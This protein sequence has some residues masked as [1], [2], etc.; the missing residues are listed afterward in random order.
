MRKGIERVLVVHGTDDVAES[1]EQGLRLGGF[2]AL[3]TDDPERASWIAAELRAD[4][5]VLDLSIRRCDV[6]DLATA[7]RGHPRTCDLPILALVEDDARDAVV[8]AKSRGCDA[9]IAG[10]DGD[11]IARAVERLLGK[12]RPRRRAA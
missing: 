1:A 11:A 10:S 12:K 5:V 7:L 2:E 8:Y 6:L 3:L 4:A 9:V